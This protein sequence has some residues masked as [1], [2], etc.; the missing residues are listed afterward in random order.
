ML[1]SKNKEKKYIKCI[2]SIRSSSESNKLKFITQLLF[3][4]FDNWIFCGFYFQD[5]DKLL[6]SEYS[7]DKIPCSPIEFDGVCGTSILN[8]KILNISDINT[9]QGHIVCDD[10]SKS[11]LCIP[12]NISGIKYVLD[13]DS[14]IYNAFCEIDEKYL[15]E[16]IKEI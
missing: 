9:F 11:E 13:V 1:L 4:S 14:N 5:N 3:E 10:N 15:L 7:S 6:V 8:N 12:F 2:E 16:I